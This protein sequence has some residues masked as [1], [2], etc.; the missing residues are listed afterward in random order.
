MKCLTPPHQAK[1]RRAGRRIAAPIAYLSTV[2]VSIAAA[3][4]IVTETVPLIVGGL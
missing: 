4:V 1:P 3:A 2:C